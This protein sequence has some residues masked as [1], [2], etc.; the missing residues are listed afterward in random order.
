[1]QVVQDYRNIASSVQDISCITSVLG[2]GGRYAVSLNVALPAGGSAI[3]SPRENKQQD[4][5]R[6]GRRA[7]MPAPM[8]LPFG[9]RT[10]RS[11]TKINRPAC[12]GIPRAMLLRTHRLARFSSLATL[13]LRGMFEP[14][15]CFRGP[16][17]RCVAPYAPAALHP[18]RT[19]AYSPL[20]RSLPNGACSR[21]V[22]RAGRATGDVVQGW[23][24]FR[25]VNS[26]PG[27]SFGATRHGT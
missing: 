4:I 5:W 16:S 2:A 8:L 18:W 9:A 24:T 10:G 7:S 11:A 13:L 25:T 23:P 21:A 19:Q 17:L 27:S 26:P 15:V 6:T 12:D 14:A 20:P 1:M 3:P 22:P